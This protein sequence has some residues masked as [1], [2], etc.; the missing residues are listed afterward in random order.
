MGAEDKI[1]QVSRVHS[2][3][4]QEGTEEGIQVT[5][6]RRLCSKNDYKARIFMKLHLTNNVYCAK[7]CNDEVISVRILFIIEALQ[8]K[9]PR[10]EI[11]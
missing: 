8:W 3:D 7:G 10:C 6:R 9:K 11:P 1:M 5:R 4:E 2:N